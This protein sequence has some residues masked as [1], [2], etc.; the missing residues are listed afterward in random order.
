MGNHWQ[1][2]ETMGDGLDWK[3][4]VGEGMAFKGY[5]LSPP[6]LFI[7]A[8]WMLGGEQLS[9]TMPLHDISVS[10]QVYGQQ[11]TLLTMD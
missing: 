5:I 4:E 2:L 7:S 8:S 1:V 3:K 11:Q 6:T 9:S 10:P